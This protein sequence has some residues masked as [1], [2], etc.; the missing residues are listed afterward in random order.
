MKVIFSRKGMD[1]KAGGMPNP[2]LPDGTLLSLPIPDKNSKLP[3]EALSYEGR[4]LQAL[5][6]QLHPRFDFKENRTCHLDPDIYEGFEGRKAGWRAAFGQCSAA[7]THLDSQEVKAGDLFLFYGMFR[8]TVRQPDGTLSFASSAPVRH[9]IYGYLRVGEILR[10]EREIHARCPWHPHAVCPDRANNRLYLPDT[11]GTFRY[12][13]ELVLTKPGQNRRSLWVLPAFF[14]EKELEIS[15]QGKRRP[16]LAGG[17]AELA[18][19]CIG[20]EFV[21]T[22]HTAELEGKLSAWAEGIIR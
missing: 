16:A 10:E 2:I 7:A 12:R 22:A 14:A 20:Q 19:S 8:Q 18:S 15:W 1:S 5:I 4:N 6:A 9:V 3:Y 21:I 11:Y 13:D 17:H